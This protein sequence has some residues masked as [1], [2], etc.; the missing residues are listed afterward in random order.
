MGM[1][2]MEPEMM[3]GLPHHPLRVDCWSLGA[4]LFECAAGHDAL[5]EALQWDGQTEPC[6][7]TANAVR[8]SLGEL[9]M[10]ARIAVE[11]GVTPSGRCL[12]AIDALLRPDPSARRELRVTLDDFLETDASQVACESLSLD[13]NQRF[14]LDP[15]STPA[16]PTSPD[17]TNHM[18]V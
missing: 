6:E 18:C 14:P 13:L 2:Y 3:A 17:A 4:V 10:P 15:D 9:G 12:R 5:A 16:S 7:E 1:P 11:S 8:S